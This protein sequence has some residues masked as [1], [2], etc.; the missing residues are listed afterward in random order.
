MLKMKDFQSMK[1]KWNGNYDIIP[2]RKQK[3]VF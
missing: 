2:I 1:E 3:L